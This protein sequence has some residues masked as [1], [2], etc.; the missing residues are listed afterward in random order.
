[1]CEMVES[2]V[3]LSGFLDYRFTLLSKDTTTDEI[4]LGKLRISASY[5]HASMKAM[6]HG[7]QERCGVVWITRMF[8]MNPHLKN[9]WADYEDINPDDPD[10]KKCPLM[11]H[12]VTTVWNS[13]GKVV[14]DMDNVDAVIPFLVE[15]GIRHFRYGVKPEHF[16]LM[17]DA[18]LWTVKQC[19]QGIWS[20]GIEDSWAEA[21]DQ[22]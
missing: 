20:Q 15:L 21:Y 7:M 16:P 17:K 18:I 6:Q 2:K 9:L 11:R 12:F 14:C 3:L 4:S 19:L 5:D 8:K 22:I 1:M 13:I 10:L